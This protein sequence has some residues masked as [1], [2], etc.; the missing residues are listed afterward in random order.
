[1]HVGT[2]SLGMNQY[3]IRYATQLLR[4]RTYKQASLITY[5]V[6][7]KPHVT[8]EHQNWEGRQSNG[9]CK[10]RMQAELN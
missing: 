10:Y 8:V 3:I 7:Q 6:V 4:N 9:P 2:T 1:M 5:V